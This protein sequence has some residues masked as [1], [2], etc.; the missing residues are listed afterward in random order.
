MTLNYRSTIEINITF[1]YFR[2]H[3]IIPSNF[4]F[5]S[6]LCWKLGKENYENNADFVVQ[7]LGSV[8]FPCLVPGT[9]TRSKMK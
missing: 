2:H 3:L 9:P 1:T 8:G 4:S 7:L 5:Y 6:L